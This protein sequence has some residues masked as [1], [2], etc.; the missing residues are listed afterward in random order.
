[1][2]CQI[3]YIII[4]D[5]VNYFLW[6]KFHFSYYNFINHIYEIMPLFNFW[7]S[8]NN[9]NLFNAFYF[10]DFIIYLYLSIYT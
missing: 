1:M 6:E 3:I 9:Q 4:I 7:N 5:K 2:M 10:Q 8:I